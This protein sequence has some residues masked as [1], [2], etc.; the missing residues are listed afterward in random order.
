MIYTDEFEFSI[1]RT[2]HA[3]VSQKTIFVLKYQ[4]DQTPCSNFA[5]TK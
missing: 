4:C 1:Q 2:A 3:E 5:N